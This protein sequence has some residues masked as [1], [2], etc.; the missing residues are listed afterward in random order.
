MGYAPTAHNRSVTATGPCGPSGLRSPRSL[1]SHG[2]LHPHLG[3]TKP[4]GFLYSAAQTSVTAGTLYAIG[5]Q[6]Y[7]VRRVHAAQKKIKYINNDP[8][9]QN[10][11]YYI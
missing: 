8:V 3:G 9:F 6:I 1:R 5:T 10:S 2:S 4:Y 7:D 11:L